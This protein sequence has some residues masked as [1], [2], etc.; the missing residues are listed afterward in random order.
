MV[1]EVA[2]SCSLRCPRISWRSGC[3]S[4]FQR[5]ASPVTR[6]GVVL[7][8]A[9]YHL[10]RKNYAKNSLQ[11][12]LCKS[13]VV[14]MQTWTAHH[15]LGRLVALAVGAFL[16]PWCAVLGATLPASARVPNWSLAWVGPALAAAVAA[17][18][19]A[20]SVSRGSPR[21]GTPA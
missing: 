15:R 9:A 10:C 3:D 21:A 1:V 4:A 13:T 8:G 17:L 6:R 16:V 18:C 11:N 7:T 19:A 5:R 14:G 20:T 2:A 12:S